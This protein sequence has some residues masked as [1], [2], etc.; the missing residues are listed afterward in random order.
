MSSVSPSAAPVRHTRHRCAFRQVRTSARSRWALDPPPDPARL[1]L[2]DHAAQPYGFFE[3]VAASDPC[4]STLTKPY[5]VSRSLVEAMA[6]GC[7]ILAWDS[8][9]VREFITPS[10]TGLIVPPDDP[11][12]AER[13]ARKALGDLASHQPLGLAAA[14]RARSC[15]AQDVTL[16]ALA[17][18]FD[19]LR[20]GM[21]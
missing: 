6:A 13:L 14:E 3:V 17:S 7:V 9:A 20:T 1:W 18:H 21:R 11:E 10:Q 12:A 15:F 8:P 19:S 2:L 4:T 5:C 16:P